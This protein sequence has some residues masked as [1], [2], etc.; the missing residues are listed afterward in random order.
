[1]KNN[2]NSYFPYSY[3][4]YEKNEKFLLIFPEIP[5]WIVVNKIGLYLVNLVTKYSDLNFIKD[6]FF[7][8]YKN[9]YKSDELGIFFNKI[10]GIFDS[11]LSKVHTE[12]TFLDEKKCLIFAASINLTRQCNL[13]CSYCYA[14]AG[15]TNFNKNYDNINFE[16]IKRYLIGIKSICTP[17]CT[18]Q[19]TGGEPLLKKE[20]LYKTI[21]LVN[22]LKFDYLTINTNGYFLTDN[23]I[24]EFSKYKI[25]NFTISL[26]GGEKI[27]NS[28]R[29]ENSFNKA[30][31]SIFKLKNAG[32]NVT[33]SMTIHNKNFD[34][35][36]DFII[37]CNKYHIHSFTSPMFPLGRGKNLKDLKAVPIKEIYYKIKNIYKK[38]LIDVDQL[39]G[40]YF[41]T[42]LLPV[43]DL[44][45]RYYCGT[46]LSTLFLDS[47]GDI[48]PCANTMC[49]RFLL[50]NIKMDNVI[51]IWNSKTLNEI[52]KINVNNFENCRD[53]DLKYICT[54]YCRGLTYQVTN[55]LNSEFIWCDEIHEILIDAIWTLS[56]DDRLF[57]EL[58]AKYEVRHYSSVSD[59]YNDF[60]EVRKSE[61]YK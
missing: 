16:D 60:F 36:E 30:L 27:H 59:K 9:Y 15:N 42:I 21:E 40:T 37:F 1:M 10:I 33:A 51:D 25:D 43:K 61:S 57:N 29:G 56:E 35:L 31:N 50:G 52:R 20:L 5:Y 41:E 3:V 34:L 22:E 2:K 12:N 14:N 26:D 48:Y 46:G 11:L 23:D 28:I 17:G 4:V 32:F 55:N 6:E 44:V 18:I 13:N 39:E 45:K 54:G 19:I 24:K 7:H 47:N 53:C 58:N 38:G 49:S 8:I